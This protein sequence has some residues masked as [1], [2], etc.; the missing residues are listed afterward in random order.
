MC[1]WG[2]DVLI[3]L[4]AGH[5]CQVNLRASYGP[6]AF[7]KCE[8][9]P[10]T[11]R[12]AGIDVALKAEAVYTGGKPIGL[13]VPD[14]FHLGH[15]LRKIHTDLVWVGAATLGVKTELAKCL[16]KHK[17]TAI[18]VPGVKL[19]GMQDEQHEHDKISGPEGK[20]NL[21]L[22]RQFYK[23]V[24]DGEGGEFE[25]FVVLLKTGKERLYAFLAIL[26][27]RSWTYSKV[28]ELKATGQAYAD[29]LLSISVAVRDGNPSYR[30]LS[31]A[32]PS[33]WGGKFGA[34]YCNHAVHNALEHMP[35]HA[36]YYWEKY[37]LEIGHLSCQGNDSRGRVCH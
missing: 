27:S 18:K 29:W 33:G 26:L 37:G 5:L 20:F 16:V 8:F 3:I 34:E 13:T 21:L 12:T 6:L 4:G 19:A 15:H 10:P 31:A 9:N 23:G 24:F 17:V 30:H 35:A 28:A 36:T 2:L 14:V 11:F 25:R 22:H 1:V 32:L 7:P